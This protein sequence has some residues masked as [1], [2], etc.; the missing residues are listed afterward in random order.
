M[1][2]RSDQDLLTAL[3]D[4]WDRNNTILTNL[5]R[6]IP[7]D[8]LSLRAT[9][10]SLSIIETFLHMHYTRVELVAEN[11]PEFAPALPRP[12][13]REE[14]DVNRIMAMLNESANTVAEAVKARL[15]SGEPMGLHYDHPILFLQHMIWHDGYHHGQIKL[16]LKQHGHA[17]E[18]MEIG[19]VIWHVWMDKTKS[20]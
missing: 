18:D 15:Q 17:L 2:E 10:T 7:S 14:R 4:S 20:A 12:N 3:L 9:E 11:A 19:K 6:A 1:P 16:A 5:L 13:W 8:Q